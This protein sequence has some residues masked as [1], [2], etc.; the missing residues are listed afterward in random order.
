MGKLVIVYPKNGILA[1][2][3][4]EI[5]S[6]E[7]TWKELKCILLTERSQFQKTS[8]YMIPTIWH[9]GKGKAM[10][11]IKRSVV[12]STGEKEGMNRQSMKKFRAVKIFYM[13]P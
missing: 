12:V 6:Y 11:M 7:K 1:P 2:K 10:E 9:S 5:S 13:T 4:N 3:A 8:Y